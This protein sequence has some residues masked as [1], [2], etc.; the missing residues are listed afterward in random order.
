MAAHRR[1]A[2]EIKLIK[3]NNQTP[4]R[5]TIESNTASLRDALSALQRFLGARKFTSEFLGE[6]VNFFKVPGELARIT[7]SST[8]GTD[9]IINFEPTDVLL[10]LV[11]AIRT[12]DFDSFVFEHED[13][14][15]KG[16]NRP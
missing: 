5:F 6:I 15:L 1:T 16:L 7:S 2:P 9:V 4:Q 14:G 13:L 12:N 3:M 10:S 11:A 8:T